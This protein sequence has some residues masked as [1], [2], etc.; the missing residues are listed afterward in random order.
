[1]I[2]IRFWVKVISEVFN[3]EDTLSEYC[4]PSAG[5][6]RYHLRDRLALSAVGTVRA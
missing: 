3:Y 5:S 2:V 4:Q 1:M 6:G